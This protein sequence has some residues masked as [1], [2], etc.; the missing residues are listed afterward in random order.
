VL[1]LGH[2]SSRHDAGVG[3]E[4]CYRSVPV[5]DGSRLARVA[6]FPMGAYAY[7][8]TLSGA[9]TLLRHAR[10]P[11]MPADWVVGYSPAAGARLFAVKPPC[12]TPDA[13]LADQTTID[14]R[15]GGDSR[16][17]T[18]RWWRQW[19]GRAL[20]L[21]RKAGFWPDGYVKNI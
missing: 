19:I 10:P 13:A 16:S 4:T 7:V 14:G 20:L 1:L 5:G 2:H 12:V 18:R 21:T 9:H 17:D 3:A 8:V 15:G 11:R 6:E